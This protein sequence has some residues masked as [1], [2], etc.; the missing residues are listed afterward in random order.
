[1]LVDINNETEH[2]IDNYLLNLKSIYRNIYTYS[3]R[4][5]GYKISF[6]N[7]VLID[8]ETGFVIKTKA[9][10]LPFPMFVDLVEYQWITNS[11]LSDFLENQELEWFKRKDLSLK[12]AKHLH[13]NDLTL[14]KLIEQLETD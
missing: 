13:D 3:S 1:M 14:Y 8:E 6:E 12:I 9:I 4:W 10:M 2:S 11:N 5:L 7:V